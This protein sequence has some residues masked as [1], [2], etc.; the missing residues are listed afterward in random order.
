MHQHH[1]DRTILRSK[2]NRWWRLLGEERTLEQVK[3]DWG[4]WRRFDGQRW[5]EGLELAEWWR[6]KAAWDVAW[7]RG[8]PDVPGTAERPL[9]GHSTP[10][11]FVTPPPHIL[12]APAH[13]RPWRCPMTILFLILAGVALAILGHASNSGGLWLVGV[14][15]VLLLLVCG[16][17]SFTA[18]FGRYI[19]GRDKDERF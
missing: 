12:P 16:L 15:V 8:W 3:R 2:R 9:L 11:D 17:G 4:R 7:F 18:G 5:V 6:L 13:R 10:L 1:F 19:S 14:G